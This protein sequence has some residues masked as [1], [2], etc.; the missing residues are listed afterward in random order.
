MKM[1]IS[2]KEFAKNPL[3]GLLFISLFVIGYLYIDNKST[4]ELRT[5]DCEKRTI[6][7]E[8]KVNI[9]ITRVNKSDSALAVATTKLQMLEELGDNI[10]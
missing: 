8:Q 2:Y 5:M 10:Q 6:V 7:L 1:P 3:T 4:Y 9:L